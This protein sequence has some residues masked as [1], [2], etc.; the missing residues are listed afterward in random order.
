MK[1]HRESPAFFIRNED[2]RT[3]PVSSLMRTEGPSPCL[4]WRLDMDE[5]D[6]ALIESVL[7]RLDA[8]VEGGTV[9]MSVEYDAE[10]EEAEKVS[11]RGC[12]V[13]G[14]DANQCVGEL[15]AYSDL[16]LKYQEEET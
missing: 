4:Q 8:E 3:V 11:H 5:I 1:G 7:S 14:R 9:R 12:R 16:H 15:D 2:R 13:Y 6:Q 10:Q